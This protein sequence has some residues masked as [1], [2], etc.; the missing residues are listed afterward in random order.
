MSSSPS[1][2]SQVETFL[3]KL[4]ELRAVFVLGRRS[5]PFLE[6]LFQFV[7]DITVLLE[8]VN[9]TIRTR[10]GH[11]RRATDQLKSVTE[12]TEVATSEILDHTEAVLSELDTLEE[13][14]DGSKEYLDDL[15]EEDDRVLALL[16]D[17]LGDEHSELLAEVEDIHETKELLRDDAD[18]QMEEIREALSPVRNQIH[19]ITI[20]LQVQDITEQQLASV[21]HLIETVRDRIDGLLRDLGT[22]QAS[23]QEEEEVSRTATFNADARYDRSQTRQ[24]MADDLVD[25]LQN[26]STGGPATGDGSTTK[27]PSTV[28]SNDL[29]DNS[30]TASQSDIDDMFGDQ[31]GNSSSESASASEDNGEVASQEDIDELFQ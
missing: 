6:E 27:S 25:S 18:S 24:N 22:G 2:H 29:G 11:M 31:Q 23:Q 15:A 9:T 5:F 19:Q 21:N 7:K 13:E 20:S 17:E 1:A 4:D 28:S 12:A 16:Q 14:I 10:T 3:N 30:G 26:R 8:E